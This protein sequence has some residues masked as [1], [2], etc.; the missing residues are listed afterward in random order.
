MYILL[1]QNQ[2]KNHKISSNLTTP[3]QTSSITNTR[4]RKKFEFGTIENTLKDYNW[5]VEQR[6]VIP[7]A[8]SIAITFVFP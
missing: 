1:P 3:A 6:I 5:V 4:T 7:D 2:I 8:K